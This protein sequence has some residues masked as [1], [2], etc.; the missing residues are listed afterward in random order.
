MKKSVHVLTVVVY[1][2][3]LVFMNAGAVLAEEVKTATEIKHIPITYFVPEKRI[4]ITAD[5][6]DEAGVNLVRCYFKGSEQADFVFVGMNSGADGSYSGTLPAPAKNTQSIEY[7]FLAVNGSNQ[8]VKSQTFTVNKEDRDEAPAW[9]QTSSEGN[10]QV[11][12][13]V[14]EAPKTVSGFADSIVMDVVESS[15]RFGLV[16]GG[17]Y[18]LLDDDNGKDSSVDD[19][20]AVGKTDDA[21]T[22]AAT[23]DSLSEGA[24][25]AS[26]DN[27]LSGAAASATSGGTITAATGGL[28]TAAIIGI[29]A[30]VAAAAGGIALA[31]GSSGGDDDDIVNESEVTVECSTLQ[32]A[33][34]NTAEKRTV[35]LGVSSGTFVFTYATRNIPDQLIIT[36]PPNGAVLFDTGCTSTGYDIENNYDYEKTEMISYSGNST[37]IQVEVIPNCNLDNTGDTRW[38]FVV[39]CPQ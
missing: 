9:Q 16:V 17:I 18:L 32:V 35:E 6:T 5:V 26:T 33:G 27:R 22:G 29:G 39:S 37:K 3:S 1:L 7:L 15:A 8:V 28:S 13:E 4:S 14:A 12:T 24:V 20:E 36:Y 38:S 30:G 21:G 23:D 10:I 2:F 34:S 19:K 11:S 25:G 31:A